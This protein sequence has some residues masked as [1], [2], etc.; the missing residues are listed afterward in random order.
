MAPSLNSPKSSPRRRVP[1]S[2]YKEYFVDKPNGNCP[3][4][5]KFVG[6]NDDGVVCVQC[7]AFWHYACAN[8][9]QEALDQLWLNKDFLC[10]N[11][12]H[13]N[14]ISSSS[15]QV[16]NVNT[17]D[18]FNDNNLSIRSFK[19]ND[20][21]LNQKSTIKKKFNGMN[22]QFLITP[23][24]NQRQQSVTMSTP[25]YHIIMEN[26]M[27]YGQ[28]MGLEIKREDVDENGNNVECSYNARVELT[29]G[30]QVHFT[31]LCYHT[32][33]RMLF[34]LLG[35]ANET[36][37]E[38]LSLVVNHSLRKK[39]EELEQ[40]AFHEQVKE[41]MR[42]ELEE[43]MVS[44]SIKPTVK[45]SCEENISKRVE[46]SHEQ[47]K[48]TIITNKQE[49]KNE[50][51]ADISVVDAEANIS[52][53]S[54]EHTELINSLKV[55]LDSADKESRKMSASNEQLQKKIK[56]LEGNE[57]AKKST[58]E[59]LE[60]TIKLKDQMSAAVQSLKQENEVLQNQLDTQKMTNESQ[61]ATLESF[62]A[63][64]RKTEQ[65]ILEKEEVIKDQE[66]KLKEKE[67]GINVH[68]D[69]AGR[70]MDELSNSSNPDDDAEAAEEEEYKTE[71]K[72][73][74]TQLRQEEGKTEECEKMISALKGEI[75]ELLQKLDKEKQNT[76]TTKEELCQLKESHAKEISELTQGYKKKEKLLKDALDKSEKTTND[77]IHHIKLLKDKNQ[78]LSVDKQA[79]NIINTVSIGVNTEKVEPDKTSVATNTDDKVEADLSQQNLAKDTNMV[80]ADMLKEKEK[81]INDLLQ[82]SEYMDGQMDTLNKKMK[83]MAVKNKELAKE[84]EMAKEKEKEAIGKASE[85]IKT[86]NSLESK[87][88]AAKQETAQLVT[89]NDEL[90][91]SREDLLKQLNIR[92]ND[93]MAIYR[94]DKQQREPSDTN[95]K[96]RPND[97]EEEKRKTE[98]EL[99]VKNVCY[100]ELKRKGGC[101]K[102][103]ETCKF[104]HNITQE[105]LNRREEILV[106]IGQRNLC[107][108]EFKEPGSCFKGKDCRFNHNISDEQ[109]NDPKTKE[110]MSR[111]MKKLTRDEDNTGR[112]GQ[113]VER[114]ICV[115][116]YKVKGSCHWKE[117]CHF[118]H[119]ISE[120]QRNNPALKEEMEKKRTDIEDTKHKSLLYKKQ[121]ESPERR[122]E[123]SV[124]VPLSILEK[125]HQLLEKN[126][127]RF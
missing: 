123:G 51:E 47:N 11:H 101:R 65:K 40:T 9:S 26:I 72:K 8:T 85:A 113:R 83:E 3:N 110:T 92:E 52:A 112:N 68:K 120:D 122:N 87:L 15:L 88:T 121:Q 82:H 28:D 124:E 108:N 24:D 35:K 97:Q 70:F 23:R 73:V 50:T 32:T 31:I 38:G 19:I 119:E 36:K 84:S 10:E 114:S 27:N 91:T 7:N 56:T 1:N 98:L 34:Q 54:I 79:Y 4:C 42:R 67:I 33:N 46:L 90:K 69:V 30:T 99:N 13:A 103:A 93:K 6:E 41:N 63:I 39:V 62:A 75:N 25:T 109:R 2:K 57:K 5:R 115:H 80:M 45:F 94:D 48:D 104:S 96:R 95:I 125:I 20:Y 106:D 17:N 81:E 89:L 16:K 117:R 100:S 12:R 60:K 44:S 22:S 55:K 37:I 116:E 111:V 71:I 74:Y 29:N 76:C 126:N 118:S 49:S 43:L 61:A 58:Q 14:K 127:L 21:A 18:C 66:T 77:C 64:I 59:K 107:V 53:E 105:I 78:E 102:G 86:K